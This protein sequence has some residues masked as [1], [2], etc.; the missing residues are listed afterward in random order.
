MKKSLKFALAAVIC[1][2]SGAS[3]VNADIGL[4]AGSHI[5]RELECLAKSIYHEAGGEPYEG[6]VA[7]AQ[8]VISRAEHGN[9]PSSVCGVISQ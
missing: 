9:F 1:I 8:V 7:V 4:K 6:K 5:D 3:S 2:I